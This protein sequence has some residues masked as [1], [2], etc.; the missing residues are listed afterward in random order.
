MDGWIDGLIDYLDPNTGVAPAYTTNKSLSRHKG[1]RTYL[2]EDFLVVVVQWRG[3]HIQVVHVGGVRVGRLWWLAQLLHFNCRCFVQRIVERSHMNEGRRN[4]IWR[5]NERKGVNVQHEG[6]AHGQLFRPHS[7]SLACHNWT[8]PFSAWL[9]THDL[10]GERLHRQL[11]ISG[12][13]LMFGGLL[14]AEEETPESCQQHCALYLQKR[15]DQARHAR[16]TNCVRERGSLWIT[17]TE[18][19]VS[20]ASPPISEVSQSTDLVCQSS[21]ALLPSPVINPRVDTFLFS[22][23]YMVSSIRVVVVNVNFPCGRIR[24]WI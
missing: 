11:Q 21:H 9:L 15:K 17:R 18:S 10:F 23:S 13:H 8:G 6:R 20:L 4:A 16:R 12:N 1:Q 7:P 14:L 19:L 3:V 22:F 24:V 2:G 5:G